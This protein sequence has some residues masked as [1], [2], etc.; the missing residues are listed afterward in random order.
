MIHQNKTRRN[1]NN[2]GGN[3]LLIDHEIVLKNYATKIKNKTTIDAIQMKN[4]L[5]KIKTPLIHIIEFDNNIKCT[6][7]EYA[8]IYEAPFNIHYIFTN[9]EVNL[10]HKLKYPIEHLFSET[11]YNILEA[12]ILYSVQIQNIVAIKEQ[13]LN[14]KL[15]DILFEY[16]P[17]N[18]IVPT[19][20]NYS[21]ES[22]YLNNSEMSNAIFKSILE[23]YMS[24]ICFSRLTH[25][26]A[27]QIINILVYAIKY[28]NYY[29]INIILKSLPDS[30][31]CL[32]FLLDERVIQII[33]LH[34]DEEL[35]KII[36]QL[37]NSVDDKLIEMI[38][39]DIVQKKR[40]CS[41]SSIGKFM[42]LYKNN[43]YRAFFEYIGK[44]ATA[45]LMVPRVYNSPKIII[46]SHG[47]SLGSEE[48]NYYFPFS[49]C[50]FFVEPGN[51][52]SSVEIFMK[53]V[54]E[55]I[56]EGNYNNN[57]TCIE[58]INGTIKLENM[59]FYLKPNILSQHKKNTIGFYIC[60]NGELTKIMVAGITSRPYSFQEIINVCCHI[61]EGSLSLSE[62]EIMFFSCRGYIG[63]TKIQ[64]IMPF[65]ILD[66]FEMT[67]ES[68]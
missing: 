32:N 46:I 47:V 10:T 8:L 68:K 25:N 65:A 26:S 57:L 67:P 6:I 20:L 17:Q 31:I 52:L 18:S 29:F 9:Y 28:K 13:I 63:E 53:P 50:C 16:T 21:A 51:N 35:Y 37:F 30:S 7:N 41:T 27:M 60:I 55:L 1:K 34:N 19:I 42:N 15:Y 49:K 40:K 39:C 58:S 59:Q 24:P 66:D 62:T 2:I 22:V 36:I 64:E 43:K 11:P 54:E 56:C 3:S 38:I 5:D 48:K 61:C 12:Y 14:K 33:L 45:N 44:Y 23:L 4:D